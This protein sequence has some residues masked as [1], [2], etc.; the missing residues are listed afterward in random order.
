MNDTPVAKLKKV[1]TV[2]PQT[3]E[4]IVAIQA[5]H[6][7]TPILALRQHPADF[8]TWLEQPITRPERRRMR[9]ALDA[10]TKGMLTCNSFSRSRNN[11]R[12]RQRDR[13]C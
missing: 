10:F 7:G 11:R 4:D 9:R 1:R 2:H 5:S 8:D 3:K 6:K 13:S 12:A